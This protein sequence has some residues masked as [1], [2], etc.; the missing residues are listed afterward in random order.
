MKKAFKVIGVIIFCIILIGSI[1]GAVLFFGFKDYT[2]GLWNSM[3]R[4]TVS[5]VDSEGLLDST[6][7]SYSEQT[8]LEEESSEAVPDD[9]EESSGRDH[10]TAKYVGDLRLTAPRQSS[11]ANVEES[12]TGEEGELGDGVIIDSS[13]GDFDA[14]NTEPVTDKVFLDCSD[15]IADQFPVNAVDGIIGQISK[16]M[17]SKYGKSNYQYTSTDYVVLTDGVSFNCKAEN[18]D[19]IAVKI[20]KTGDVGNE[21]YKV[22]FSD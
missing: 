15:R 10:K 19:V 18:G 3:F 7:E 14:S 16:Y 11:M 12:M 4:N 13:T 1:V 2:V 21:I 5:Q 8:E 9:V 22:K 20:N 17:I 6:S